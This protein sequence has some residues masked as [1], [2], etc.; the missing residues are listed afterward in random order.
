MNSNIC[1]RTVRASHQ[2]SNKPLGVGPAL[3]SSPLPQLQSHRLL[4][5]G[6]DPGALLLAVTE[7]SEATAE[8]NCC[9]GCVWQRRQSVVLPASCLLV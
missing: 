4:G 1:K 3:L 8:G 2:G 5:E 7:N 9:C 6:H